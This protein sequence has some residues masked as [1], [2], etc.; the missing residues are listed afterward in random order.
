M[1][2]ETTVTGV[3]LAA[4]ENAFFSSASS[5]ELAKTIILDTSPAVDEISLRSLDRSG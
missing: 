5:G 2:A 3:S 1:E 4:N